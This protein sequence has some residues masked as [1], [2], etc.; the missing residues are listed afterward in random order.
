[1]ATSPATPTTQVP[2]PPAPL[3]TTLADLNATVLFAYVSGAV[4]SRGTILQPPSTDSSVFAGNTNYLHLLNK[5]AAQ[6]YQVDV[7]NS[8][9]LDGGTINGGDGKGGF[10]LTATNWDNFGRKIG[11]P[12]PGAPG[13]AAWPSF[14]A[15]D[16][17]AF[18]MWDSMRMA[19][20]S[21]EPPPEFY[22]KNA[23]FIPP[24]QLV[25]EAPAAAPALDGP[26]GLPV[27][28]NPGVYNPSSLDGQQYPNNYVY[29]GPTGVYQKHIFNDPFAPNQ[30]RVIWIKTGGAA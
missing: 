6:R 15:F 1:M 23:G 25:A 28:N 29:T 4:P 17:A 30:T 14:L 3:I 12:P 13:G 5:Q 10:M 20:P 24:L 27:P 7:P 18:D 9:A 16:S 21:A 26:I 19:N 2:V 8:L 22:I 11:Q